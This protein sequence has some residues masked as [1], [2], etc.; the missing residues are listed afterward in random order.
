MYENRWVAI[1]LSLIAVTG[2]AIAG[3]TARQNKQQFWR[4]P[5][6]QL[7]R[8]RRV[9][10]CRKTPNST[11]WRR[12]FSSDF[13][14]VTPISI[15]YSRSHLQPLPLIQSILQNRSTLINTTLLHSSPHLSYTFTTFTPPIHGTSL[16]SQHGH[17]HNNLLLHLYNSYKSHKQ[18]KTPYTSIY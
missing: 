3:A 8:Q 16:C 9:F 5:N 15:R 11:F 6:P 13:N 18:R 7:A 17:Q 4:R 10:L 1:A 2:S 12:R 14:K